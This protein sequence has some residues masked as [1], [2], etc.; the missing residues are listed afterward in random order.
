MLGVVDIVPKLSV[1]KYLGRAFSGD[2]RDRGSVA[3]S[4][5]TSCAWMQYNNLKHV[6]EN[7]HVTLQLRFKLFQSVITSTILYSLETCPL[8]EMYYERLDITQRKMMRKMVGWNF[9]AGDTWELAGRKM[10]E[11]LHRCTDQLG[12]KPWSVQVMDRKSKVRSNP[13]EKNY[14]MYH[15]IRWYPPCCSDQ[16]NFQ[17]RR[18]RGGQYTKW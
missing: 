17:W 3:L 16:N 1:H 15:A 8:T 2:L 6:L 12:I 9:V 4:Y 11:R 14:W 10:K 5:R 13:T 18:A 7:K